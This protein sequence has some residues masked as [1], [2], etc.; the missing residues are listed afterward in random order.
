M[1]PAE[2]R[3]LVERDR[4]C[5][6]CGE[7]EAVSP[8]HRVNRGMGGSKARHRPA[9]LVLICSLFNGL[10]ESNSAAA[11]MARQY[12]W[13]LQS[14]DSPESTPVHDRLTGKWYLIDNDYGR[15]EITEPKNLLS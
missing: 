14:W 15:A 1:K 2:F 10:I 6:H 12:G 7:V 3:K 13:K 5:L 4:Y 11:L 8:N 9:N